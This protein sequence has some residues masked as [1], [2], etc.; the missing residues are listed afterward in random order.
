MSLV[1]LGYSVDR[2]DRVWIPIKHLV[3]T[4]QTQE[5]GKTTTLEALIQRSGRRAIV[6]R[7]K[8]GEKAFEGGPFVPPYFCE[9]AD[10]LYV[11]S[12]IDATMRERHRHLRSWLMRV[13]RT[14]RTLEEVYRNVQREKAAARGFAENVYTELEGYLELI[15][16]QLAQLPP[17]APFVLRPG[18]NVMDLTPYSTEVQMLI[19]RSVIDHIHD[20][21]ENVITVVPEAWQFLPE[22]RSTPVKYA[23][24]ALIRKGASV[25][26]YVWADSQDLAGI[27]K[28]MIRAAAVLLIGVQK[29]HNE[30]R[31]TL[32][33]LPGGVVKPGPADIRSL[34]RGEFFYCFGSICTKTYVQPAWMPAEIALRHALNGRILKKRPEQEDVTRDEA[35]DL[36]KENARLLAVNRQLREELIAQERE[37][38]PLAARAKLDPPVSAV[39]GNSLTGRLATLLADGFFDTLQRI[40]DVVRELERRKWYSGADYATVHHELEDFCLGG[41]MMRNGQGYGRA[42]GAVVRIQRS[43]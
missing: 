33:N 5:A 12:L 36:R 42:A 1:A 18:L 38:R 30:V 7:T 17:P 40:D 35:D 2:G 22:S 13:C 32:D 43:A 11:S 9:R 25:G 20:C 24:E 19:V 3:V 15:L 31:R 28:L 4:G 21:E 16:P 23:A 6:F 14:T 39:D 10:W 27:S 34:K 37:Y 26:N 41:Y 8:R 29:E